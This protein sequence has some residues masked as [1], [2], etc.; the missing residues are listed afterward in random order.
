VDDP[1]IS[2]G[3]WACSS[4]S[5]CLRAERLGAHSV[6]EPPWFPGE[7]R[8]ILVRGYLLENLRFP[9]T[10]RAASGLQVLL[11]MQKVEGSNP[12]SRFRKGLICRSFSLAQSPC[13]SASGRTDSGLAAIVGAV[14]ENA[15]FAGRFS[16]V[17][18]EVIL[19]GCR[20]TSVRLLRPAV[21]ANGTFLRLDACRRAVSDPAPRGRVRF[22]SGYREIDSGPD[23]SDPGRAMAP[24]PRALRR[25]ASESAARCA[26][27]AAGPWQ[28]L[29]AIAEAVAYTSESGRLLATELGSCRRGAFAAE[30]GAG[31]GAERH[32][33][34]WSSTDPKTTLPSG[35]RCDGARNE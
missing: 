27:P 2:K 29:G 34:A 35:A 21:P 25:T 18:A 15:R 16:F 12:F 17:R 8:E 6:P 32:F 7:S 28:S 26:S 13:S 23:S 19:Q 11:A 14:K 4:G 5:G 1:P 3:G 9:A 30:G 20:M 10:L 22:Q 33:G 24:T 31:A